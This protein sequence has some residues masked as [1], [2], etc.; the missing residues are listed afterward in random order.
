MTKKTNDDHSWAH[1][2]SPIQGAALRREELRAGYKKWS[3]AKEYSELHPEQDRD[4]AQLLGV[5]LAAFRTNIASLKT[6]ENL[7]KLKKLQDTHALLPMGHLVAIHNAMMKVSQLT[8]DLWELIDEELV[9]FFTPSSPDQHL[10]VR[11]TVTRNLHRIFET[12]G[13]QLKEKQAS[14]SSAQSGYK[15]TRSQGGS[16][17]VRFKTDEETGVKIDE[18]LTALAQQANTSKDEAFTRMF[19]AHL[20]E[21]LPQAVEKWERTTLQSHTPSEAKRTKKR[22]GRKGSRSQSRR[23]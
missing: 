23:A 8:K 1:M 10:P 5:G 7:P 17:T 16:A 18:A 22:K 11:S 15:F 14:S 9:S 19:L 3:W 4:I 20:S 21:T 6:L 13:I 2:S 12:L